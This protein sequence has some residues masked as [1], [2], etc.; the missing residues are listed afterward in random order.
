M[1]SE[2]NLNKRHYDLSMSKRTRKPVKL[3]GSNRQA[4]TVRHP[5]KRNHPTTEVDEEKDNYKS[6]TENSSSRVVEERKNA[7]CSPTPGVDGKEDTTDHRSVKEL[8][9]GNGEGEVK[10]GQGS[11]SSGNSLGHRFT[12]TEEKQ[13]QLVTKQQ[14]EGTE[15]VKTGGMVSRYVKALSHLIKVKRDPHLGSRKKHVLRL[16]M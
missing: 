8:I 15:G 10:R 12:F 2:S 3:E 4:I 1:G 5:E 9:N 13:L 11:R 16:K 6:Q 14:G 7:K